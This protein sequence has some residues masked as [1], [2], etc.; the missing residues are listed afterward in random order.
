MINTTPTAAAGVGDIPTGR[1]HAKRT[2]QDAPR[3]LVHLRSLADLLENVIPFASAADPDLHELHAVDLEWDGTTLHAAA[4]DNHRIGW[5]RLPVRPHPDDSPDPWHTTVHLATAH[6]LAGMCDLAN[7]GFVS[8]DTDNRLTLD[9]VGAVILSA[10]FPT[11]PYRFPAWRNLFDTTQFTEHPA[12][13]V[14]IDPAAIAD[15]ARVHSFGRPM[16]LDFGTHNGGISIRVC[17]GDNFTG[18]LVPA[19]T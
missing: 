7:E 15:F 2:D 18:L 12:S 11:H 10:T 4:T 16:H 9:L 3:L 5:S 8:V 1:S 14:A 13:S 19:R 6:L 17:I